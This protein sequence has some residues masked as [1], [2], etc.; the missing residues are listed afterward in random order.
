MEKA[1][2]TCVGQVED[3]PGIPSLMVDA[4]ITTIGIG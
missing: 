3:G 2:W 4:D 1:S